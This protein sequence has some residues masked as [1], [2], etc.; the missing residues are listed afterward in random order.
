[1]DYSKAPILTTN[2]KDQGTCGS[3]WAFAGIAEI[4][5]YFLKKH[6]L[7][8]DLSEQQLIDCLPTQVNI[9]A[10]CGSGKIDAVGYYSTLFPL[11]QERYY[12]Y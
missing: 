7:Y 1:M 3:S 10:G 11:S 2:V 8:L 4:E 5:S 12:P 6:R 9:N